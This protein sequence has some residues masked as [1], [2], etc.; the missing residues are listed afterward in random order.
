MADAAV[1]PGPTA[2]PS[3]TSRPA[4]RRTTWWPR[5]AGLLG[6][7]KVGHSGTLDPDATG[8]LV[9]G[10]GRATR[11]LTFLSGLRQALRGRGRAGH[12]HVDPRRR[13]ARS[14]ARG[15]WPAVGLAD[16]RA[17]AA[18]LTGRDRAGAAD[19]V[20]QEGRRPPAARA[21][22]GRRRG[23]A[24]PPCRCGSSR[25][26]WASRWRP[27]CSRSTSTCSSGTYIRSLAADL[28]AALGGGAHLRALRRLAVG[29]YG[30]DEAVALE[31]A[32]ARAA[33][34][35]G[36]GAARAPAG[37]GRRR[38][39]RPGPQ[40]PGARRRRA[41]ATGGDGPWAVLGPTARCSPCTSATAPA[42]SSPRSCSPRLTPTGQAGRPPSAR[43][44][45]RGGEAMTCDR[46]LR[47]DDVRGPHAMASGAGDRQPSPRVHRSPASGRRS[48]RAPPDRRAGRAGRGGR[49]ASAGGPPPPCR[50]S[51]GHG[52]ERS[53]SSSVTS[54]PST[55]R[56]RATCAGVAHRGRD[57]SR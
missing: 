30:I 19:G 16:V 21:G 1:P 20:G 27:A 40:R 35:A 15:T 49:G 3:S 17:A 9:L 25:S 48:R 36:R 55:V 26:R 29:P 22:P 7:R 47:S 28:G 18:G 37:D 2:S 44:V 23:R 51:G 32:G 5:P 53:A 50:P 4:G 11:L 57:E 52:G 6:T 10:V 41:G 42:R 33:A 46:V 54:P 8:V 56:V 38:G 24:R 34:A 39:G 43:Q 14:P 13:P 12:G 31:A 45:L